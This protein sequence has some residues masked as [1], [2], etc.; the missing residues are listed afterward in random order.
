[1]MIAPRV[2]PPWVCMHSICTVRRDTNDD[3]RCSKVEFFK[4]MKKLGWDCTR[5][6][7]DAL[8]SYIDKEVGGASGLDLVTR[9]AGHTMLRAASSHANSPHTQ[10]VSYLVRSAL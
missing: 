5:E 9:A 6:T 3:G 10:A 1:M 4:G 7:V 8:F 2:S